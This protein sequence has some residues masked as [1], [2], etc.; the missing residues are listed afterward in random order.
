[1]INIQY[2]QSPCGPLVLASAGDRLCLCDWQ[3]YPC[4][5]RNLRRLQRALKTKIQEAP[6]DV[7]Q[8]TI[9]ELEEFFE[10]RRQTFDIPLLTVGTDFQ[11]SVWQAL[12]D[13]PY[14]ETR[15]YMQIAERIGNRK[16]VRAVAQAIGANGICIL[17]PCHRVVGAN[18]SLTG[19]AGGLEAKRKLLETESQS[20]P[21]PD[22]GSRGGYSC[23]FGQS[24]FQDDGVFKKRI[25]LR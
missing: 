2:Y 24:V 13:I 10:G 11:K 5:E 19:F 3:D 1:M 6:S 16:G 23:P 4:A 14:G 7:L 22:T 20:F 8:R 18:G 12:L 25:R 9:T 17:I 15:S 21:C